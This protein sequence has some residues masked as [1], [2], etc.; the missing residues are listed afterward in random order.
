MISRKSYLMV[1]TCPIGL[2]KRKPGSEHGEKWKASTNLPESP[3]PP[4]PPKTGEGLP[5]ED[6]AGAKGQGRR[7]E[8]DVGNVNYSRVT[9]ALPEPVETQ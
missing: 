4:G 9:A 7:E 1:V 5:G 3:V 8:E 6:R 2:F